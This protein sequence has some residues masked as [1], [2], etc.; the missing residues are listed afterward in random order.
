MVGWDNQTVTLPANT[1]V[2]QFT[3]RRAAPGAATTAKFTVTDT[4]GSWPSFVG[5]GTGAGF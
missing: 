2:Q 1:T 4:C 5:G 3:V